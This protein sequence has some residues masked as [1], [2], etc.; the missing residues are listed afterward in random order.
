MD[1]KNLRL[2]AALDRE[3]VQG[4]DWIGT[5]VRLVLGVML[6]VSSLPKMAAPRAF[7]QTVRAFD[8]SPE[9]VSK[10]VAYTL[11]TLELLLAVLLLVGLITRLAA[12]LA[13]VCMFVC[14]LALV[15]A[16]VRGL[17]VRP[18]IFNVGGISQTTGFIWQIPLA[19]FLL[20]CALYLFVWP[21]TRISL[22][23]Y[24]SRKDYVE[25]PSAKRMRHEQ[26]RRKYEH[27]LAQKQQA[28]RTRTIWLN[29]SIA[30]V[31]AAAILMGMGVLRSNSIIR[32]VPVV[33]ATAPDTGVVYGKKAAA[34]VDIYEDFFSTASASFA[35]EV[36]A[37]LAKA[38]PA[39]LAQVRYHLVSGLDH[40]TDR[41]GYSS[42]AANSALC[43]QTVSGDLF[44]KYHAV[45]MGKDKNGKTVQP[46]TQAGRTTSDFVTYA[47]LAGLPAAD[48]TSFRD[49]VSQMTN[50][51][52]VEAMTEYASVN[53][54]GSTPVV[55]V[56]GTKLAKND[57]ATL[58]AAIAKADKAGPPPSP[59]PTASPTP[60]STVS[61]TPTATPSPTAS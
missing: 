33:T 49:C 27:E 48:A 26:G 47:T 54:I 55:F 40:S 9:W 19:L 20:A 10:G 35:R 57:L 60:T 34:T 14:L 29:S 32:N 59:S 11:P 1:W 12:A 56:N 17:D 4:S 44:V 2:P 25:P 38:V 28:A 16:A 30:I 23:E 43:A 31:A 41:S 5:A 13:A 36:N 3:P 61:A 39:N 42:R 24:L 7:K 51:K 46:T 52:M 21:R 45:L 53:G 6:L 58:T 15:Q 18:A 22:D 50:K 37:S 8:F